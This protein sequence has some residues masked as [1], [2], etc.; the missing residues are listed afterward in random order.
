MIFG[1]NGKED[2]LL[3]DDYITAVD[4]RKYLGV[5]F[6]KTGNSNEKTGNRVSKSR[7]I[8]R[9]QNSIL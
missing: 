2:L 3:E 1:N 8:I 4:K 5:L 9:S 7:N 6:T